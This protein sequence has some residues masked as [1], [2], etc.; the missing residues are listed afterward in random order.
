MWVD[1]SG[2]YAVLLGSRKPQCA[3]FQRWVLQEVLPSIRRSGAYVSLGSR[4]AE[5]S[6]ALLEISRSSGGAQSAQLQ[7]IG[8]PVDDGQRQ[9]IA[10]EGGPLYVSEFLREMPEIIPMQP[11]T[12]Q[13]SSSSLLRATAPEFIPRC[14][15]PRRLK[16]PLKLNVLVLA[17]PG[18]TEGMS[19]NFYYDALRR[20]ER[21][22]VLNLRTRIAQYIHPLMHISVFNAH[23]AVMVHRKDS[24]ATLPTSGRVFLAADDH[25]EVRLRLFGHG[26]STLD[27]SE[28]SGFLDYGESVHAPA[29]STSSASSSSAQVVPV[30]AEAPVQAAGS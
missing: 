17:V 5:A 9:S 2:F 21:I 18:L 26:K 1:E 6:P 28:T 30:Q 10:L 27:D 16:T 14:M 7:R 8:T 13:D 22:T 3:S 4:V 20:N 23:F 25:L 15:Q 11:T 12:A 29:P 24:V 19:F